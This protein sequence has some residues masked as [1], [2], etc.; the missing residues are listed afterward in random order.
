MRRRRRRRHV[1]LPGFGRVQPIPVRRRRRS[2]WASRRGGLWIPFRTCHQPIRVPRTRSVLRMPARR[3]RRRVG[4][5]QPRRVRWMPARRHRS[6]G[7]EAGGVQRRP[8]RGPRRPVGVARGRRIDMPA[9]RLS[10]RPGRG[11]RRGRLEEAWRRLTGGRERW[12][13]GG[14]RR[15]RWVQAAVRRLVSRR[16][17]GSLGRSRGHRVAVAALRATDRFGR[18]RLARSRRRRGRRS[19]PERRRRR[20]R[21]PLD[22]GVRR[23]LRPSAAAFR[24]RRGISR[25]TI[26]SPA[27]TD[28]EPCRSIRP[29]GGSRGA[30]EIL[31]QALQPAGGGGGGRGDALRG[32][33]RPLGRCGGGSRRG[34]RRELRAPGGGA[35]LGRLVRGVRR[36]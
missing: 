4:P 11:P 20:A 25:R 6:V 24:Q 36:T 35:A 8:F 29:P 28:V 21:R 3:S 9:P 27:G 23:I 15:R 17:R 14:P 19:R 32:D 1:G 34:I 30:G 18:W 13:L 10:V 31:L 5:T 16:E 33:V 22:G 7:A 2:V 26:R 12:S